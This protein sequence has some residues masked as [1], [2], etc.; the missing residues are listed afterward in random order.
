MCYGSQDLLPGPE[1]T[2]DAARLH[3]TLAP[4]NHIVTS[5]L[6]RATYLAKALAELRGLPITQDARLQEMNFG[7]WEGRLWDDIPRVELDIWAADLLNARPHG[8]ESVQMMADRVTMA[9]SEYQNAII[10]THL[11]PI[12]AALVNTGHAD[13]W[14]AQVDFAH[15]VSVS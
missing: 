5:P 6:K 7:A 1:V 2:E 13:G 15:S 12:R 10:V 9:L 8:G 3:E 11:G 4:S 14:N